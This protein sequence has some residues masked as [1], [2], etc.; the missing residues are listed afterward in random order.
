MGRFT[1]QGKLAS[2]SMEVGGSVGDLLIY[3]DK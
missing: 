2:Q 1:N 3:K